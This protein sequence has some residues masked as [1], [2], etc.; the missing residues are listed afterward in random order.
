MT[1]NRRTATRPTRPFDRRSVPRLSLACLGLIASSCGADTAGTAIE[2]DMAAVSVIRPGAGDPSAFITSS[3]WSV[4]LDRADVT[5]GPVYLHGGEARADAVP[6]L[7]RWIGPSKAY[8]HPADSTFDG[9][10]PLGEVLDQNILDLLA[11]QPMP[12]GRVHGLEGRAQTFEIQLQPP[13][14]STPGAASADMT[15]MNGHS[16]VFAGVARR[17]DVERPFFAAGHLG[18]LD[19]ERTISSIPT[20]VLLV[21]ASERPG[22]LLLEVRLDDWFRLVDFSALSEQD[23]EGRFLLPPGTVEGESLRRGIRSRTAYELTWSQRP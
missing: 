20:D 19:P 6:S 8:A 7:L 2:W 5:F 21:D 12:L 16:F 23:E 11:S 9:G 17:G 15:I 10:P 4:E 3:G 14:Y 1:S 18:E 13:G 22:P